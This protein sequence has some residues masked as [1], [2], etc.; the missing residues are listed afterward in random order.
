MPP[1]P[2]SRRPLFRPS[3]GFSRVTLA[4]VMCVAGSL[5]FIATDAYVAIMPSYL[6][7]HRELVYLSGAFEVLGGLGLLWPRTRAAAGTGLIL[8][9]LAVLPANINMAVQNIQPAGFH[10]PVLALWARVPFQLVLIY[11][12]W[13]VS[14]RS[15]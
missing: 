5:H 14:R 6:P 12:V 13:K 10:I 4:A 7:L 9:Y 11:W 1:E 8:L 2:R 15:P 3:L